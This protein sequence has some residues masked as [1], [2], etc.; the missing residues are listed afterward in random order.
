M[1]QVENTQLE[2]HPGWQ[3]CTS[4][5]SELHSLLLGLET[6]LR[7]KIKWLEEA[8]DLVL[9]MTKK[10][11]NSLPTTREARHLSDASTSSNNH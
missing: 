8:E 3:W 5:G 6:P 9:A 2:D 4:E 10:P 11:A 1:L 7:D